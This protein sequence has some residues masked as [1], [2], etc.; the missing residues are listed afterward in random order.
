MWESTSYPAVY[1]V[2]K[3]YGL[4]NTLLYNNSHSA[5][6]V[7]LVFK[8]YLCLYCCIL[9]SIQFK[10]YISLLEFT[11]LIDSLIPQASA[12][13]VQAVNNFKS[14]GPKGHYIQ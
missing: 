13:G 2:I 3:H 14:G 4:K 10:M 1:K 9:T 8:V 12:S 5:L 7:L 11:T 6:G